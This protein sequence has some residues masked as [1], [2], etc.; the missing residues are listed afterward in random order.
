[1]NADE[2]EMLIDVK[3]A[4]ISEFLNIISK[5]RK[6]PVEILEHVYT[7]CIRYPEIKDLGKKEEVKKIWTRKFKKNDEITNCVEIIHDKK[8]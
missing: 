2:L 4:R 3:E 5:K 8:E 6:I 1:M 7:H